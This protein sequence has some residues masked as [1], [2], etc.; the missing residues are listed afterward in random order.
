MNSFRNLLLLVH[1]PVST[2]GG[3]LANFPFIM[4]VVAVVA[5]PPLLAVCLC[6]EENP[7]SGAAVLVIC[8]ASRLPCL[9][10]KSCI[11]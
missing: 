10:M 8:G 7:G 6:L 2:V 4:V 11:W 3:S 9:V 5:V 1:S